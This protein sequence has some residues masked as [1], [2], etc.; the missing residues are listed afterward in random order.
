MIFPLGARILN[1]FNIFNI[2][3]GR[4]HFKHVCPLRSQDF[5]HSSA[6]LLRKPCE[7]LRRL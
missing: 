5:K 6:Q 4:K 1:I 7:E 3:T 2:Y